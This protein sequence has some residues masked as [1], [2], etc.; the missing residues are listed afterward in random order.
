MPHLVLLA[1]LVACAGK[2]GVAAPL[3]VPREAPA[4]TSAA[5]PGASG[6]D[7]RLTGV[8]YPH[9]VAMHPVRAQEQDLEM[10]YMDV[11][12][13]GTAN[14]EVVLLLHGKNFSGGYWADTIAALTARGYRVVVP[15]QIGFGKSSKPAHFQY[16]FQTLADLTRSLL[17]ARGV[18]RVH[19]V[20]HSMGGMLATRFALMYPE[21]TTSLALVN[22]IGL[23]DWKR[24][25]PWRP[26]EWWYAQELAST[27]A[28]VQAYMTES[29][30]AGKWKD[31]YA[32]LLDIQ[33]GWIRGPD[34]ARVAWNA[35]LTYDMIV[36]QPVLYEFDQVRAPTLLLVGARDRTALGKA[37]APP[38]VRATLGDYPTLAR[39][40][41]AAIPDARLV[42]LDDVGH[43][44]QFEAPAQYL[45][46]LTTFLGER[47]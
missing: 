6:Y 14:G 46:A 3:P 47:R 29:Y 17:D 12:A 24:V 30:F 5:T 16:S 11:P 10:A 42:L 8:A 44:P 36:T 45:D 37:L 19:V 20:G 31:A 1:L 43:V 13:A 34:R 41:A 4:A 40:A 28:S 35:A 22:P 26:V 33:V 23:E 21:R 2:H 15:D 25:V 9:P 27:P 38:E 39:A 18:G 7:A 32:P